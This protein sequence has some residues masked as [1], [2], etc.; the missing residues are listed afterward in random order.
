M[1]ESQQLAVA[2]LTAWQ[3]EGSDDTF[4]A[5]LPSVSEWIH[6]DSAADSL[7]RDTF[8]HAAQANLARYFAVLLSEAT[9]KSLADIYEE[10]GRFFTQE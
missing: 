8:L 2:M 10:A 1:L 6:G 3:V 4:N 7:L 9:G 5:L